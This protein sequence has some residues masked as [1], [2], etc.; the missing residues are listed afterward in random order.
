MARDR[1]HYTG[2]GLDYVYLAS[3]FEVVGSKRGQHVVIKDME[4]LHEAIGRYIVT[5]R[6]EMNGAEA[7]FLRH[8]MLM[9]QGTLAKLL[10]VSEQTVH[11]WEKGKTEKVPGSA[12][13]LLRL[14]YLDQVGNS[15]NGGIR[16]SLKRI[17]D[18]EDALDRA[19]TMEET[20]TGWKQAA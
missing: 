3:G 6:K 1:F 12:E 9:S 14:L 10:K 8:E 4:G 18:I 5:E 17:A 20:R 16:A 15:G 7:R 2:C 19:V 11:R 13:S